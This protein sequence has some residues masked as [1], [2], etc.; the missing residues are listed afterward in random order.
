MD[1]ICD[2]NQ[3]SGCTAC[4]NVCPR[5]AISMVDGKSQIDQ[6]I[7]IKCCTCE[8]ICPVGAIAV[9]NGKAQIDSEKCIGREYRKL[10]DW[11]R[12][13]FGSYHFGLVYE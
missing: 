9:T 8:G 7:C 4:R 1:F 5:N 6:N 10:C 13:W 11:C 3:C 12:L 2:H